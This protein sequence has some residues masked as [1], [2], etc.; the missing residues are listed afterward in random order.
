MQI[1]RAIMQGAI[2]MQKKEKATIDSGISRTPEFLSVLKGTG[3]F[4]K[5]TQG[6][7]SVLIA[8]PSSTENRI[9]VPAAEKVNRARNASNHS[10][11]ALFITFEQQAAE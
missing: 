6:P 3:S 9:V 8:A 4:R 1:N 11:S 2:T 7:A 5:R 10:V